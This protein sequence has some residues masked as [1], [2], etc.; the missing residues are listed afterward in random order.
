MPWK[1]KQSCLWIAT[2]GKPLKG[3]P[4]E[5]S[6]KKS[7]ERRD[8]YNPYKEHNPGILQTLMKS[9]REILTT[10]KVGKTF[11][12]PP[13][14]ISKSRDTSKY[15]NTCHKDGAISGRK[16]EA[17]P[18]DRGFSK[19]QVNPLGEISLLITMRDAPHHISKQITFLIVRSESLQ[20]MLFGRTV[21]AELGMIPSTTHSAVL[22]QSE[23][24]PKVMSEYQDIRQCE[25]FK[26]LKESLYEVPIKVF[27]C[28]DPEE[29]IIINQKYPEHAITIE[30]Q[31]PPHFKKELATQEQYRHLRMGQKK[32]AMAPEQSA[33]A[34]KEVKELKKA[35]IL[36][37]TRYQ[38]WVANT[39]MVKKTDEA[40]RMCV[41]FTDINKAC[42]KDCY[43]LLE[44]DWKRL[45]DK[46]FESQIGRNMEAYIDNMV[47]SLNGKLAALNRFLSKSTEKTLPFFKTLKGYMK[48]KDFTWTREAE[49]AF[50]EIKKYIEKLPTLMAP[51]AGEGLIVYLAASKECINAVLMAERGKD[52]IPIYFVSRV[53]HG[54]ELNYPTMEKF[55]DYVLTLNANKKDLR[56]NLEVLKE[57]REIAAI[58]EAGY[59]KK[60]EKYYKKKARPST[61]KRGDYVLRLNNAS[62][63]EYT[64]K[65][66]PTWEGP[67]KVLEAEGIGAYVL[68]TLKG[69]IIPTT[70]NRVNL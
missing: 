58:R 44:I 42:L 20:N 28:V 15:C 19:E 50:E 41:D 16:S 37:E 70:W 65:M 53:L 66:G 10:K 59:K 6:E 33:A 68:S 22:Y 40:W 3:R 38:T 56:I 8:M 4:W 36:R 47:Q 25:Q 32:R 49:K 45:V 31:L 7:K 24:G 1:E 54:A 23:E 29:K 35:E 11:T 52:Q 39:V 43:S 34:S 63:M 30:R 5:G 69:R 12:K 51:R 55:P 64:G 62:K 21:I 13:K 18:Y 17:N 14:M 57:R 48:K 27:E 67:Y 61:Y 26:R 9:S 2:R 46:V 60:L